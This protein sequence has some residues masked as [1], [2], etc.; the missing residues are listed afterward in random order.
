MQSEV[1]QRSQMSEADS[2]QL[3]RKDIEGVNIGLNIRAIKNWILATTPY[4]TD[5]QSSELVHHRA[6]TSYLSAIEREVPWSVL[7]TWEHELKYALKYVEAL[8][9]VIQHN[10]Q[11]AY[12]CNRRPHIRGERC[13]NRRRLELP[14]PELP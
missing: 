1:Q 13:L 12:Q 2:Y 5:L 9:K 7:L 11:F 8:I 4:H 3:L 6:K 10:D 14:N